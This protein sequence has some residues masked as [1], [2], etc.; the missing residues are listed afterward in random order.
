MEATHKT[1]AAALAAFQAEL[2]KLR[3]DEKAKV[4]GETK[5]GRSYDRSYTY[6]GLDQVVE[7]VLPILGKHGLSV[8]ATT[9]FQDGQFLLHVTLLHELG[10]DCTA[11]WPL[12]DPR[13][14]GP[15]DIGSAMTY[16]R[17]YLTLA[18]TGCFP[19]G[20]DDDGATAQA[21]ARDRWEDARP[22]QETPAEKTSWTDDE[23]RQLFERIN[24]MPLGQAVNG[25]DWM[26]SKNLHNRKVEV[27]TD[28]GPQQVSATETLA[29]RLAD[30]AAKPG[31]MLIAIEEWAATRGLLKIQVSESTTLAEE[32]G[33]AKAQ[34]KTDS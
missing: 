34:T 15:Q 25:Y 18:L 5:D 2:P 27:A 26:A 21:S 31:A 19:G 30:E 13:K 4:K 24:T 32:I 8:T 11:T 22:R 9:T 29:Y 28:E 23:V 6:A 3:K 33:M 7:T 14:A 16:G 12:P 20:E 17:R 1:L 10:S